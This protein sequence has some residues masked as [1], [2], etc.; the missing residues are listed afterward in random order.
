MKRVFLLPLVFSAATAVSCK[1]ESA[2][3]SPSAP[4]NA[5]APNAA[6]PNAAGASA[7]TAAA[8]AAAASAPAPSMAAPPV[9]G[10]DP[11]AGLGAM[12]LG[13]ATAPDISGVVKQVIPAG[14]Y[15]YLELDRGPEGVQ[16]AAVL[17]VD[18]AVG[19]TVTVVK[20][21]EKKDFASPSLKRRF[22][23]IWFGT[24]G[25]TG[26][27]VPAAPSAPAAAVVP[28]PP[29]GLAI[30]AIRKDREALSGKSVTFSGRV[31]KFNEAILGRNWLHVVDGSAPDGTDDIAVTTSGTAAV[32]AM[33]TVTGN[34]AVNQDFGSGYTYDLLVQDAVI[35]PMP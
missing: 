19:A 3:L 29:G 30:T 23:S 35:T 24:L 4:P 6:A 31:T 33:V 27:E 34:V 11:H 18:V 17:A 9:H 21:F 5:T 20:P 1:P 10:G 25:Q 15:T 12:D 13:A 7:P 28:P 26:G 2:T 22:D 16:W 8:P 32:G 14:R